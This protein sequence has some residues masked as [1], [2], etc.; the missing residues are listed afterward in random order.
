MEQTQL[1]KTARVAG[2]WYLMLAASGMLGFM[3]YHDKIFV[4]DNPGQTLSNLTEQVSVARI[5]LL[6]ELIIIVSQ[7]LAAVWFYKLFHPINKTAAVAIALWGTVNAVAIMVSAIAMYSAIGITTATFS[8]EEKTRMVQILTSII[9]NAWNIGGLF[10]GLWLIP[11][12]SLI[13]SSGRMPK[14]LGGILI[15]GGIGYLVQTFLKS[16]GVQGSYLGMLVMPATAAELWMIGYLLVFGIR[17]AIDH[18]S[19]QARADT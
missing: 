11:M 19:S 6:F 12:G 10:F 14:L 1:V 16:M 17:P 7:A 13:I 8:V 9:R 4:S 5:R 2:I 3:V 18:S 15:L